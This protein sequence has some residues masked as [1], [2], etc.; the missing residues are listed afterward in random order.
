MKLKAKEELLRVK[1]KKKC[2][3][4]L[5]TD[6]LTYDHKQPV[7]LGGTDTPKNIQVLCRECNSVKSAIPNSQLLDWAR[8][9][10]LVINPRRLAEGKRPLGCMNR[11]LTPP[12]PEGR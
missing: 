11:D 4:C 2:A 3:Y 8:R 5:S 12:H 1:P 10:H 9:V 6:D 7:I